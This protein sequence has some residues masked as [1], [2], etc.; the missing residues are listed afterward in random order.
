MKTHHPIFSTWNSC[1]F[2]IR[3]CVQQE[4]PTWSS[5][6]WWSSWAP[7]TWWTWSWPWW[8]WLTTSRT[9]RPLRRP[10]RRRRSSR[11]CLSS[12]RGNRRRH[13]QDNFLF[14]QNLP[15]V[16]NNKANCS[17]QLRENPFLKSTYKCQYL[18]VEC[19]WNTQQCKYAFVAPAASWK[20]CMSFIEEAHIQWR[21]IPFVSGQ[22]T[23][24]TALM[25]PNCQRSCD[26]ELWVVV[27][28]DTVDR[29]YI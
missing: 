29:V 3:L 2:P 17:R 27:P 5:L 13:R 25:T 11:L 15:Y 4:N 18:C 26:I 20:P 10:S 12:W 23:S 19:K 21:A 22:P 7:F 24:Q 9:R 8:P 1:F 14:L 6:C 16:F 28:E